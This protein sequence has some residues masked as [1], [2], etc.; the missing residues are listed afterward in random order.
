MSCSVT[1]LL[2]VKNGRP[3]LSQTLASIQ[4]QTIGDFEVLAWD[5]G[6]TDGSLDELKRW[7]P[8]VLPGR[9]VSDQ[10]LN[11]G[12]TL[13]KMVAAAN[14]EFC[15]RIDADDINFPNRLELQLNFLRAHP[16]ISI[17]GSQAITIDEAGREI[18]ELERLPL[19]HDD[20]VHRMLFSWVM[21]APSVLFRRQAILEAGNYPNRPFAEDYV[22][23]MRLAQ[24]HRLANLDMNLIKYRVHERSTTQ[25][26]QRDGSLQE[27]TSQ[28]F[29]TNAPHLFGCSEKEAASLRARSVKFSM[30]L[31]LRIA[32]HLCRTQGGSLP[33][34]LN[35]PSWKEAVQNIALPWDLVTQLV[36][37]GPGAVLRRGWRKAVKIASG[38]INSKDTASLKIG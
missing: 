3:F 10:P 24:K 11:L 9:I 12:A 37:L 32:R 4:A 6:S 38:T 8:E 7:I 23:W 27:A 36:L 29:V 31:L 19:T 30:P 28:C 14:T 21:C 5:N 25:Q 35:S 13:A 33:E 34:R 22:L 16:D 1:W 15:A 17:V 26:T 20:I 2:P 18:G